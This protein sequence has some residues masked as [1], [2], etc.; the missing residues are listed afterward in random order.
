M[1][2]Y[3]IN[4]LKNLEIPTTLVVGYQADAVKTITAKYTV[5][6]LS[7]IEQTQQ[8]GTGDALLCTR[9]AWKA[10]NILVI[11]GDMPLI[12]QDIIQDLIETHTKENAAISLAMA[13]NTDPSL[14]GYGRIVKDN[15][16][17]KIIEAKHFSG[18]T[19]ISCCINAGIYLI[20]TEF[21][22]SHAHEL[23]QNP[24][25]NEFY[26]TDLIEIAS[27]YK[28]KVT[29]IS[30]NFDNIRGVNTLKE[31][32]AA[33]QIKRAELIAYWKEKGVYFS[34]AQSV[35]IDLNVSIGAE[36]IVGVGSQILGNTQIGSRVT[37]GM[38]CVIY[39]SQIEDDVV[40]NPCTVI[41]NT[42]IEAGAQVGPFA[43]IRSNSVIGKSSVI[44][45]FVEV[46]NSTIGTN[47]KSKH[48]SYLGN[49]KIGDNVNI[50]GGTIVC[51]YNGFT[52]NVTTVK[53]NA[54]IG[55]N[56]CLVAPIIIG[57]NVITGA[58]ST[59][60]EDVPDNALAIA[61]SK[62]TNKADYAPKLK[63]RYLVKS[64]KISLKEENNI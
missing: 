20:N 62:Q 27:R 54:S 23:K 55:S 48:L 10:K 9:S 58:G 44:G 59:I 45:N 31:L 22:E 53:N 60:T 16:G 7:F 37:I 39:N 18:D 21:L 43:H 46:A 40:I 50:G 49:A 8:L 28:F 41:S 52:K 56:N 25:T 35:H 15:D 3:P 64:P 6:N 61:R 24:E 32:W 34:L 2:M 57:E 63:E 29:T 19:A 33:E 26:I 17:I 1:I 38:G 47:S 42:K 5:E 30:A 14:K 13:H 51:N 36:T 12:T 4:L 11:N